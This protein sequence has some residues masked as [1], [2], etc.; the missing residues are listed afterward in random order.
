MLD[1][2]LYKKNQW[3]HNNDILDKMGSIANFWLQSWRSRLFPIQ[4]GQIDE[5]LG[6]PQNHYL[7]ELVQNG[8]LFT[9]DKFDIKTL[10]FC[11]LQ[12]DLIFFYKAK[13]K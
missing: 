10:N 11:T 4:R 7:E 2:Y 8:I 12:N 1:L 5:N 9:S 13:Y 3:G 6:H